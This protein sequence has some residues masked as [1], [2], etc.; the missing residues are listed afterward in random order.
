M[1]PSRTQKFLW[2]GAIFILISGG[3]MTIHAGSSPEA[4][5]QA[6]EK[7]AN[8]TPEA[9]RKFIE[10]AETKLFDLW[11]RASRAQWVG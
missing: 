7:R 5:I 8:L 3:L 1:N 4:E 10:A 2:S 11:I 6:P 9:A